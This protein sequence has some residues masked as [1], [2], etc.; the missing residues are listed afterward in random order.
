[1]NSRNLRL[2]FSNP[3]GADPTRPVCGNPARASSTASFLAAALLLAGIAPGP[4]DTLDLTPVADTT[5][6]EVA[7]N[8]NF[9]GADFFSVGTAGNRR[10][11]RGLVQFDLSALPAGAQLLSAELV[12]DVIRQPLDGL[13]ESTFELHRMLRSWGEGVGVPD[14]LHPGIGAPALSGEAT[15]N[16]RFAGTPLAWAA[17]GGLAGTDFASEASG[18]VSVLGVN[19]SPY[20]IPSDPLLLADLALWQAHPELNFGWMIL[21]DGEGTQ[22]TARSLGAREGIS[23][24]VLRLNFIVPE[25]SAAVLLLLGLAGL[26]GSRSLCQPRA[27]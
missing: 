6:A 9:G 18:G 4:A 27:P 17:P 1:M 21:S 14:S 19:D 23:P 22:Y 10:S 16:H 11:A 25:P 2:E 24:A 15:W 13:V 8:N 20:T 5:L 26:A 3:V 12:I 7:V